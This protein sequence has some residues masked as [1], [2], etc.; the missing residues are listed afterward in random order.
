MALCTCLWLESP[1][2]WRKFLHFHTPLGR[3]GLWESVHASGCQ[4][5]VDKEMK[6]TLESW[7]R[8]KSPFWSQLC[9]NS[10][11]PD[12]SASKW[13]SPCVNASRVGEFISK[14]NRPTWKMFAIQPTHFCVSWDGSCWPCC[15][16]CTLLYI[17]TL[18]CTLMVFCAFL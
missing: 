8:R 14:K 5:C 1:A 4:D 2:T 3:L 7:T 9:A 13:A 6:D 11:F 16:W 18:S 12:I 17:G 15:L 10:C